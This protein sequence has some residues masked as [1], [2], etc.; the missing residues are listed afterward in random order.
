MHNHAPTDYRCP[1]C[2]VIQG[3]SDAYTTQD[4][5][6]YRDDRITAMIGSRWW[7]NNPGSVLVIPNTH[8]EN[9]YDISDEDI[10]ATYITT[11]KLA[12]AIRETYGCDGTSTRQHNEPAGGQDVWHFHVHVFPRYNDDGLYRLDD[13]KQSASA[14]ERTAFAAKLRS[15]FATK[16]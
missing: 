1:F 4:D 15:Y 13:Q 16:P 9:I 6:V 14:E 5:V 10:A 7:L 3:G 2:L 12:T 11:K 8:A